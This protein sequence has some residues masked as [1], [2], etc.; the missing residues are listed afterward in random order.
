VG[1]RRRAPEAR[2]GEGGYA[3]PGALVLSLAFALIGSAT[4]VRSVQLLALCR[5]EL[6]RDREEFA[7]D[8]AQLE[9]AAAIIRS[10]RDGPYH[11]ALASELGWIDVTAEPESEKLSLETVA[12]LSDDVFRAFGVADTGPLR[13]RLSE[14]AAEARGPLVG[15]LD[16]APSWRACASRFASPAGASDVFVPTAPKEPGP[17]PRPVSWRV[18]QA[19]RIQVTTPA[20]WRD[21]R[22]VRFTGDAEHPVA[23]ASRWVRKGGEDGAECETILA[24]AFGA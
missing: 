9:A 1:L 13:A 5:A 2:R 15:A 6:A 19:W 11:W 10:G 21:E 3:T 12:Q 17:G 18:G 16:A 20:G 22:I 8:G 4:V 14:A 24:S 7:M 23:V